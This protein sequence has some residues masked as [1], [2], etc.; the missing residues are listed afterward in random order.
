MFRLDGADAGALD[1]VA[2]AALSR[3]TCPHLG[4]AEAEADVED[5]EALPPDFPFSECLEQSAT[6]KMAVV[7][8]G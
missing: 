5:A 4:D 1:D 7:T 8:L 3:E 2:A 6:G